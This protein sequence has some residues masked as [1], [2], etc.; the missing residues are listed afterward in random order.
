MSSPLK[1]EKGDP[2]RVRG[3][4]KGVSDGLITVETEQGLR[5]FTI[6]QM[7]R[8]RTVFAPKNEKKKRS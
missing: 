8:G 3:R 2:L 5:E 4:I 6:S 7:K 1:V